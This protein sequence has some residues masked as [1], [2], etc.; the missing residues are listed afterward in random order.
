MRGGESLLGLEPKQIGF[1]I[2]AKAYSIDRLEPPLHAVH[3][4]EFCV[5]SE[6]P[7]HNAWG[8]GMQQALKSPRATPQVLGHQ[9]PLPTLDSIAPPPPNPQPTPIPTPNPNPSPG[10]H[11]RVGSE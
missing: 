9:L 6:K 11:P 5:H 7:W 8:H 3:P 4:R 10:S 1:A 2:H